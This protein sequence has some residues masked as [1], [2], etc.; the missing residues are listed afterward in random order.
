MKRTKQ[1]TKNEMSNK[2]KVAIIVQRYGEEING[3]AEKHAAM[4]A[5]HLSSIY[6]ITILTSCATNYQTWE[7]TLPSGTSIENNIEIIRFT[8]PPKKPR[9]LISKIRRKYSG[10]TLVN[11]I[12]S[13]LQRPNWFRQLCKKYISTEADGQT[14][15]AYQGP[16]MYELLPYLEQHKNTYQAFIF[17]T[18]L[19]YPTVMGLPIVANKSILIPT[20]HNEVAAYYPNIKNLFEQ[21]NII[22]F[23]TTAEL[24]FAEQLYNINEAKKEIVAVGIDEVDTNVDITVL[25]KYNI[26]SKYILYVGRIEADKGTNDI[27]QM[28]LQF[29]KKNDTQI[30]LVLVGKKPAAVLNNNNIIYTDYVTEYDKT[31]IIK[32]CLALVVPSKYESLSLVLLEAFKC[33]KPTIVNAACTVLLNHVTESGGG[34]AYQNYAQFETAVLELLHTN[35]GTIKGSNGFA[36]VNKNYSWATVID[37]YCTAIESIAT[38]N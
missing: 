31:Q 7:P 8:H 25:Y 12:F 13:F 27:E 4:I 5:K 15:L 34:W 18:Y 21:A 33:K 24:N 37:K 11:K 22:F 10:E 23:N 19:Y 20:L 32:Q 9:K 1:G 3:G 28:F 6:A 2:K 26:D 16:A 14:W 29:I 30:K 35:I 38:N 36:Y 17:F